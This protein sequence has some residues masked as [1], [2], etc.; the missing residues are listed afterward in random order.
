MEF[1][2]AHYPLASLWRLQNF[3]PRK[4]IDHQC[5]VAKVTL[6]GACRHGTDGE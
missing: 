4:V 5:D 1:V 2:V 3:V 6:S